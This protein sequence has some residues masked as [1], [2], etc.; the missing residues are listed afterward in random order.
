MLIGCGNTRCVVMLAYRLKFLIET[1]QKVELFY[2]PRRPLA[3]RRCGRR[4]ATES[5]GWDE[6]AREELKVRK[7]ESA[8][9]QR[10]HAGRLVASKNKIKQTAPHHEKKHARDAH[11][12][13]RTLW[14]AHIKYKKENR[15]KRRH[16]PN[17]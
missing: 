7:P 15:V 14:C 13:V 17:D 10:E 12:H 16:F 5:N 11:I 1:W 3:T 8:G 6:R 4:K 2:A 9:A